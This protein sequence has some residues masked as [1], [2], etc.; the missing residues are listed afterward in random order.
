MR[1][2]WR[3]LPDFFTSHPWVVEAIEWLR[4][5][6]DLWEQ[7]NSLVILVGLWLVARKL[8]RERERLEERVDT[9]SQHVKVAKEASETA[10]VAAKEASDAIIMAVAASAPGNSRPGQMNGSRMPS[11]ASPHFLEP[12]HTNWDRVNEIWGALKDRIEL[13]IQGISH[14][15]V[16]NK[17]S[18]M[19]RRTYRKIITALQEDGVLRSGI[20]N[21]LRDLDHQY[22]VLRFKARHVTTEQ[23]AMFME[24]QQM[25]D[26]QRALPALPDEPAQEQSLFDADVLGQDERGD[27]VVSSRPSPEATR[28]AS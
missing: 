6:K 13:K 18:H 19:P 17:Y 7:Y 2:P 23:V 26:G 8:S 3:F 24:V 21:R 10:I 20:A 5:A 1:F 22:Q 15:S 12:D 9:L 14:K 16:R 25:V 28:A 27:R 4:V 11:G